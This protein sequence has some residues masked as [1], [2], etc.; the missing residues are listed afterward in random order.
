MTFTWGENYCSPKITA[1]V[2][3]WGSRF[4]LLLNDLLAKTS[5]L[6]ITV[7]SNNSTISSAVVSLSSCNE[8]VPRLQKNHNG[9][10]PIP[11]SKNQEEIKSAVGR[12][13]KTSES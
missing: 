5:A 9:A 12:S 10:L 8:A 6:Y 13:Q 7:C 4:F 1:L 2:F 3:F 11:K